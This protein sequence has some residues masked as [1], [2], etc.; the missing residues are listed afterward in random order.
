MAWL[1]LLVAGLCEIA[2]PVGLKRS[3]TPGR[4]ALGV[5]IA[6]V[7]IAASGAFPSAPPTRSGSGSARR[8][9]SWSASRSTA[10]PPAPGGWFRSG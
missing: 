3:Q 7:G 1:Y 5:I 4:R 6:V 2:W 8:A 9:P 10:I